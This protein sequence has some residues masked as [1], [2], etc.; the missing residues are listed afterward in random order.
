MKK[1]ILDIAKVLTAVAT[2]GGSALW[3]DAK[4]DANT[5]SLKDIKETVDYNSVEL[6]LMS[7]DIQGIHDTLDK[8]ESNLNKQNSNI[9]S[10][11]WAVRNIDNFTPEQLEEILN[12]EFQRERVYNRTSELEAIP[13]E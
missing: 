7:E 10:L 1:L 9:Q 11:G 3:F 13:I 4:F 5:E 2:I 12:R 6:S 8:F